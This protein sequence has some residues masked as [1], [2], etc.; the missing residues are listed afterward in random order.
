LLVPEG[1][2]VAS[3]PNIAHGAVR[4]ALMQG[5]FDYRDVGLLDETHLRFFTR[6]SLEELFKESGLAI[7]ELRRTTAPIWE[8][9]IPLR[10]EDFSDEV[11]E[12]VEAD[13]E[14]TTYQ[15]VATAVVD[16]GLR[17]VWE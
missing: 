10:R 6:R 2:V 16:N 4:L 5:R 11:V 1:Y 17:S 13:P 3:V 8:T 15:F 9:E 14:S 7:A 12:E